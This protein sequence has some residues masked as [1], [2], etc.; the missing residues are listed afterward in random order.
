MPP[1]EFVQHWI[2]ADKFLPALKAWASM[3]PQERADVGDGVKLIS[4]WQDV[5]G[6]RAILPAEADFAVIHGH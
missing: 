5:V 4:R 1:T 6:R 2:L 3:S